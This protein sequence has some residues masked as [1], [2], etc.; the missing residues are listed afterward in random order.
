MISIFRKKK[1]EPEFVELST[2]DARVQAVF[3]FVKTLPEGL[4]KTDFSKIAE[5]IGLVWQGVAKIRQAKTK[6]E[7]E[8]EQIDKVE[9]DFGFIED[10]AQNA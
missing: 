8:D 9:K 6:E 5:G 4:T 3:D 7:K 2:A 10:D 1:P